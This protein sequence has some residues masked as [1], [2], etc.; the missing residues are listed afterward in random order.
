MERGLRK[1][2]ELYNVITL[3]PTSAENTPNAML[4]PV[5]SDFSSRRTTSFLTTSS[6]YHLE[7]RNVWLLL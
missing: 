4:V 6:R 7:K 3:T 2:E 1:R 5:S